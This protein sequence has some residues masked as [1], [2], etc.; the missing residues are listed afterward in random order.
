[1]GANKEMYQGAWL[2]LPEVSFINWPRYEGE[3]SL[4]AI[5]ERLIQEYGITTNDWIGGSSLGGMVAIEIHKKIKNSK[6]VLLGS[7]LTI[8]EIRPLLR[9]LAPLASITPIK[10]IQLLVKNCDSIVFEMFRVAD[11]VFIKAMCIA[12]ANWDGY[13]GDTSSFLR[14]HGEQD[15][16][17]KCP[18]NA[19]IIKGAGHF[20]AMTHPDECICILEK[21]ASNFLWNN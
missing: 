5:A 11:P 18:R 4:S 6:V 14:I 2:K 1:M 9:L 8:Q 3:I 21:N 13:V 20:V 10:L 7:A 16:F 17:I 12:A 19:E 15:Q